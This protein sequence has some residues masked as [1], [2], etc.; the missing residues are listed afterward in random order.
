[1]GNK[2]FDHVIRKWLLFFMLT[3]FTLIMPGN[4]VFAQGESSDKDKSAEE[5]FSLEEIT[6]TGS[7]LRTTGMDTPTPVTVVQLDEIEVSSPTTVVEG[8]AELPQFFGSNTTQNTG[9]FFTTQEL[10]LES[11]RSSE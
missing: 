6:V 5:E 9:G 1:M 3:I 10:K 8:L 11:A 7:R 2:R 4:P